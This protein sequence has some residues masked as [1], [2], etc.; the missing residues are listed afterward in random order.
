M[1]LIVVAVIIFVCVFLFIAR[2]Y[3]AKDG[4]HDRPSGAEAG[5]PGEGVD[6]EAGQ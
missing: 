1:K 4:K 5:S 6:A 3:N 2:I